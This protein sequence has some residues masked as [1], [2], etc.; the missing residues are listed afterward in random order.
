M[1]VPVRGAVALA[2]PGLVMLAALFHTWLPELYI[3][4]VL[5]CN[6]QY[7]RRLSLLLDYTI[8]SA[9]SLHLTDSVGDSTSSEALCNTRG[10]LIG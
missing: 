3:Y 5:S 10:L 6:K 1:M 9:S 7:L 8:P 4:A 2:R